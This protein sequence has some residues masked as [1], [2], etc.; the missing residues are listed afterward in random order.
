[1]ATI[2]ILPAADVT[3]NWTS[4]GA[5]HWDE[6]NEEVLSPTDGTYVDTT[7][8]SDDFEVTFTASPANLSE[9][10]QI[11]I[12]IRGQIDDAGGN[13]RI[14]LDL[15]HTAGTPIGSTVYSAGADFGGYGVLGNDFHSFTTLTLTKAEVDTL[16]AE[17]IFLAI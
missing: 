2:F 10:T 3:A 1:M 7:T 4:T 15:S 16:S 12:G 8:I 6:I 17:I 5:N 14:S 11:D 13:A 9:C